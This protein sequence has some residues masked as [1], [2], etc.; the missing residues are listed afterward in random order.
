MC[1]PL[2][3]DSS[4][5]CTV[6]QVPY[7]F[8]QGGYA[9]VATRV[10]YQINKNVLAQ[11]NINNLFDRTYYVTPGRS[12]GGNWYGDPRNFLFTVNAKF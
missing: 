12:D 3:T 5:N 1:P 9:V 10:A 7:N 4:G 2:D 8:T 6:S 11:V